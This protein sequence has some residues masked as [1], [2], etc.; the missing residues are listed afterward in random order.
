MAVL[1]I[2][3]ILGAVYLVRC[4]HRFSCLKRLGERRRLP[5]WLLSALPVAAIGLFALVNVPTVVVVM[6]HLVLAFLLCDLAALIARAVFKKRFG[7]D[8]RGITALLLAAVY[9]G[10]GWFMAYHIFETDYTFRTDKAIGRDLRIVEIADSHLGITLDGGRFARQME[11]VQ[12]TNPDVVVIAG[13]FVDDDSS[14]EDMIAACRALGELK[15][16]YGVYFVFGNHDDGYFNYRDFTSAELRQNLTDN[17]V[18][19]LED[20]SAGLGDG[21]RII[22]RRD[23]SMA[24]RTGMDSLTEGIDRSE[25]VIVLDHQPNDYDN[26]AAAGV[27]LVLSGHTH[28]G[29]I[30][31]AG[32]IGMLMGANDC[33]YGTQVRGGTTFV[34]TSGISGWAIPFKTG[35]FSEFVVI[36]IKRA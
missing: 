4:F 23:R 5:A 30:F 7:H 2:L 16:T 35:T 31:P 14:A 34:V 19:I 28:G 15:T 25:Y 13:D 22:G 26:E 10:V 9:L 32:Q 20:E 29:H 3:A 8:A 12:A 33:L 17:G 1:V 36:D 21:F 11:R 27:D 24:G 6:L 18:V